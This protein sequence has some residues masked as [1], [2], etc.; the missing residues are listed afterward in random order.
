[1]YVSFAELDGGRCYGVTEDE[2]LFV[3]GDNDRQLWFEPK[4]F[5]ECGDDINIY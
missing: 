3:V 2:V 1:V 4:P 5:K